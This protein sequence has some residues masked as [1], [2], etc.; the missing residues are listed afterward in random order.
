M[1]EFNISSCPVGL[2]KRRYLRILILV[3]S[4]ILIFPFNDE[5][6]TSAPTQP[7]QYQSYLKLGI[8]KAF[9]MEFINANIYLQKAVELD[10]EN[11]TAYAL[12]AMFNL[13]AYEMSFDENVRKNSRDSMLRYVDETIAWGEK[14]IGKNPNDGTAYLAMAMAKITRFNFANH[15]KHYFSTA[16]EASSI[17]ECLEKAKEND[18]QN[19]DVYFLMGS[20][21]YHIDH[22]PRLT[23]FFSSLII[24]SGDKQKG[25]EELELAAQKG[26]LLQQLALSELSADYLNFEKQPAR[27]LPII[28]ELRE[29]FPNNYNFSFALANALSDLHRFDDAFNIAR[30][31]E[32]NIRT[33]F[34]SFALQLQ[35]RRDHL[36]GRI[37][38][39]QGDY[40]KAEEYLQRALKD[41]SPYNIR[42]RSWA[43]LRLGMISDAR[44]ERKKAEDYYRKTLDIKE[45]EGAAQNEAKK[46]LKSPYV[47]QPKNGAV[48]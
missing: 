28:R 14:R 2:M 24:T 21:R 18:P 8:K 17:W 45:G 19:Y 34:P 32:N 25:L 39:T 22:L 13:F 16:R 6:I 7:N 33:C 4:A 9:N 46:Y 12:L 11:P 42:V 29:T 31:I 27:A 20:F 41:T 43:F 30:E 48:Q 5:G 1:M 26:E 23:R 15:H 44:N 37:F 40:A 38:F 36:M 35:P 3:F 10:R 47:P